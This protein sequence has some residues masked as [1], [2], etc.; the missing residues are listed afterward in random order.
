MQH[1]LH[2][3]ANVINLSRACT[4][5]RELEAAARAAQ[6][7][8]AVL[9]EQRDR[10]MSEAGALRESLGGL[11]SRVTEL[12]QSLAASQASCQGLEADLRAARSMAARSA[13]EAAARAETISDLRASLKVLEEKVHACQLAG[14]GTA[15]TAHRRIGQL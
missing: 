9:Q 2:T 13:D 1:S 10:S 12:S 14:H 7:Q 15:R 3:N 11:S 6:Q 8:Q 4:F 5:C